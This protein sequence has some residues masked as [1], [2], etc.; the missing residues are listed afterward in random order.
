MSQ[1]P[2]APDSTVAGLPA[3]FQTLQQVE[4]DVL[5][6]LDIAASAVEELAKV[7]AADK[8]KLEQL[9][10]DFLDTVKVRGGRAGR[11]QSRGTPFAHLCTAA[12]TEA[13]R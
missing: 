8:A 11:A 7:D 5:K 2:P 10:T 9:V 4:L 13:V 1:Q 3:D 6:S 12:Q